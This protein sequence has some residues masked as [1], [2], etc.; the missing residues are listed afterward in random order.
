MERRDIPPLPIP[1]EFLM[2]VPI[3]IDLSNSLFSLL[4]DASTYLA[5]EID[6]LI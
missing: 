3:L 6:S 5:A 2:R 1:V 4:P